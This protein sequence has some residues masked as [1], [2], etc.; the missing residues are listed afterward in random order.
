MKATLD[1]IEETLLQT[2]GYHPATGRRPPVNGHGIAAALFRHIASRKLDPRLHG[3]AAG[4]GT[5]GAPAPLGQDLVPLLDPELAPRQPH[6]SALAG[7]GERTD[8]RIPVGLRPFAVLVRRRVEP[9]PMRLI[10]EPGWQRLGKTR[11]GRPSK[12]M[13]DRPRAHPGRRC[14]L[15]ARQPKIVTKEPRVLTSVVGRRRDVNANL[16]LACW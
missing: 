9:R 3:L 15:R 2:R 4:S 1:W 10:V 11:R 6:A 12:H 7:R 16:L 5:A 13:R 8:D 14:D